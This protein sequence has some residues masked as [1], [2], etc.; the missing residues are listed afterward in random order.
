MLNIDA[1]LDVL[2]ENNILVKRGSQMEFRHRYWI[3]YFAAEW[4]R[5]DDEFRQFVLKDRNYVNY[6]EII[7]FYSGIN[8]KRTDAMGN[9]SR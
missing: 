1:M 3:F 9:A 4:M 6:P 7:E 5:H 2:L 8:G